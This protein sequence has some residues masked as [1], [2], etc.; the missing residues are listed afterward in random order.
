M[1]G[2]TSRIRTSLKIGIFNAQVPY[3]RG[4]AGYY[5]ELRKK[6]CFSSCFGIKSRNGVTV[7]LKYPAKFKWLPEH[8]VFAG[9]VRIP[10]RI[11]Q[12]F[13]DHDII[14]E[15]YTSKGGKIGNGIKFL[16]G[17]DLV[18]AVII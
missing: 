18:T 1:C 6:A 17:G 4:L 9:G 16:L 12:I 15:F 10:V 8:D 11:Q 13:I 5:I 2:N 3:N 7:A 14:L